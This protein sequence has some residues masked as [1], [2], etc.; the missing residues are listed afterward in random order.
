MRSPSNNPPSTDELPE[1]VKEVLN[2]A[3]STLRP[4]REIRKL[5]D[6][7]DGSQTVASTSPL[8]CVCARAWGSGILVALTT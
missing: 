2:K 7:V 6:L 8:L 3:K 5:V 1:K 4:E